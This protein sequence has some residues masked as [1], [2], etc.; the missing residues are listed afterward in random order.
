MSHRLHTPASKFKAVKQMRQI[1]LA[2]ALG[3][4]VLAVP[5]TV[6]AQQGASPASPTSSADRVQWLWLQIGGGPEKA[7]LA[8]RLQQ[9]QPDAEADPAYWAP[10][11]VALLQLKRVDESL[12]WYARQVK[13]SPDDYPWQVSYADELAR[14]GRADEAR[15]IRSNAL[16]HLKTAMETM[17]P[18]SPAQRKTLL[19]AYA[20]ALRGLEGD[21][22]ADQ[23]LKDMLA[24]GYTDADVYEKLVASSL[25]QEEY[26][27]AGDWLSRAKAHNHTLP[28]YL[29]LAVA[30]GL[31]DQLMLAEVLLQREKELS[32]QD[33]VT[34]LRR[35]GRNSEALLLVEA[36]LEDPQGTS[37]VQ[38]LQLQAEL[39]RK[40]SR[41]AELKVSQSN[42][43]VL[44]ITQTTG[45]FSLPLGAVRAS[46][47]VTNFQFRTDSDLFNVRGIEDENQISFAAD[48]TL[49]GVAPTRL[50]VGVN[51]RSDSSLTF[52]R[53]EYSQ[54][55][56][57][58]LQLRLDGWVNR[59]TDVS[60]A[61]RLIGANDRLTAGLTANLT[62]ASYGR[63]ELAVQNYH[64]RQGDGL[65]HGNLVAG[66][67]GGTVYAGAPVWTWRVSGSAERNKVV[68]ELPPALRGGIL[69]ETLAANSV[70]ASD[71][72]TLGVGSTLVQVGG[73][74]GLQGP[75]G[76]VLGSL[77]GWV[78]KQWP[79]NE[80]V[81]TV[82]A[83]LVVPL[84]RATDFR[85]EGSY[86]NVQSAFLTQA[87][88]SVSAWL[89][90]Y[91]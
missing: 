59:V 8:E 37:R 25:A 82:R 86:G 40:V 13:A 33:R 58:K 3:C 44:H 9:W 90:Y 7:L 6:T 4:C 22:A 84:T 85:L 35:L 12:T 45:A 48:Y 53:L 73:P 76:P 69:A 41:L 61:M 27:A 75:N 24:R 56:N 42:L 57:R 78:G 52:G 11:A 1:A 62:P 72:S 68:A 81:Y 46:A 28:A 89:R 38:L 19:L 2:C 80:F 55:L 29:T 10:Y 31:N 5:L 49:R 66:E 15:R 14:A 47:E 79:A 70:L 71:Y 83:T 50:T 26:A 54:P 30:L 16:P 63:I 20:S 60:A 36:S 74:D 88:Q 18:L 87:T 43:G 51:Q 64:T 17:D 23:V 91:F 21:S 34:A 39:K 67:I 32:V 77:D 65:G